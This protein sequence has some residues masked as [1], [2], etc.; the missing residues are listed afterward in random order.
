MIKKTN[1]SLKALS[2]LGLISIG[3]TFMDSNCRAVEGN[4]Q[5]CDCHCQKTLG[6]PESCVSKGNTTGTKVKGK[7]SIDLCAQ[8]CDE[9][10]HVISGVSKRNAYCSEDQCKSFD[11]VNNLEPDRMWQNQ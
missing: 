3:F 11:D 1:N 7:W 8:K 10:S 5:T 6:D 2:T 4:P 9:F